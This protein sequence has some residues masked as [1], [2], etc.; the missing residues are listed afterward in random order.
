MTEERMKDLCDMLIH[1]H[2][3]MVDMTDK[4][5][6]YP[7][8]FTA[9]KYKCAL[10]C[11]AKRDDAL[12]ASEYESAIELYSA[13]NRLDLSGKFCLLLMMRDIR[14]HESIPAASTRITSSRFKNRLARCSSGIA[15]R[16]WQSSICRMLPL[17]RSL[18]HRQRVFG[19]RGDGLSRNSLLLPGM[20]DVRKRL[21]WVSTRATTLL[22][23]TA[24]SLFGIFGIHLPVIYGEKKMRS[25]GS[26]GILSL[27]RGTLLPS[28]GSDDHLSSTVAFGRHHLI[29]SPATPTR[30]C[31]ANVSIIA[32]KCRNSGVGFDVVYNT[33]QLDRSSF[34]EPQTAP[35]LHCIS[36]H[37]CQINA[38]PRPGDTYHVSSQGKGAL[39]P[40]N[41]N[42]R[43]ASPVLADKAISADVLACLSGHQHILASY[44]TVKFWDASTGKQIGRPCTGHIDRIHWDKV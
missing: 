33:R 39:R 28:T 41:H 11:I 9:F 24:Y 35:S 38:S 43:Q 15:I 31:D 40:A 37:T 8:W 36:Y 13:A 30:R 10:R 26:C 16:R 4:A 29:Q 14:G 27:S 22:E 44:E 23:D 6:N 19:I 17:R 34:R 42:R 32:T 21:R 3:N 7:K 5:V 1:A 2:Q 25:G 18:E 12:A 20:R